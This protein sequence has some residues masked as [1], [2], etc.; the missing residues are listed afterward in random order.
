MKTVWSF[1]CSFSSGYLDVPQE[2]S[3]PNLLGKNLG[4]NIINKSRP[5][6]CNDKIFY[7][8]TSNIDKIEEGDIVLY[9]FSSFNRIGFFKSIDENSYF[10][11][12]GIPELGV[13]H[14]IKET[15]FKDFKIEDLTT[16]LD[17]IINW[18]PLRTKYLLENPLNILNL[19]Q[20]EKKI[21]VIILFLTNEMLYYDDR[22]LVLPTNNN[23]KNLS[24]NDYLDD[25]NLTIGHE[26]PEKYVFGDT[27]PG[28]S[29][30]QVIT[31][32]IKE[33]INGNNI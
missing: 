3:Y 28:F 31:N 10:S 29:G 2:D 27:H 15:D 22:V 14:K 4:Y 6:S 1:G 21:T 8:L 13:H 30:H 26:Y 11:S 7:E 9:Q 32:L 5:G 18:Q 24:L 19:L 17:F 33:K 12:A 20:K 16:L 25:N 23:I